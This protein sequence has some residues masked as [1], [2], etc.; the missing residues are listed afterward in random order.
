MDIEKKIFQRMKRAT[1]G[2]R[3]EKGST[4]HKSDKSLKPGFFEHFKGKNQEE[5]IGSGDR[6][7][8]CNILVNSQALYH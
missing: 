4:R 7:R 6:A 2:R 1:K 5:K 3:E 8:T